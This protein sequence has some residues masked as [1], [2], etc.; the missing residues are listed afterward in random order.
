MI[1]IGDVLPPVVIDSVRRT[2][3]FGEVFHPPDMMLA[4]IAIAPFGGCDFAGD[5]FE[6]REVI[7][8]VVTLARDGGGIAPVIISLAVGRKVDV[9]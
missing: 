4:D 3:C 2:F 5:A 1:R 6:I 8:P 9:P 7:E